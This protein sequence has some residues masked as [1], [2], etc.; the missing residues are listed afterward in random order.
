MGCLRWHVYG[1]RLYDEYALQ[2]AFTDRGQLACQI[3]LHGVS[4][5]AITVA[6]QRS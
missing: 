2:E 1:G 4:S 5:P 3:E 6:A